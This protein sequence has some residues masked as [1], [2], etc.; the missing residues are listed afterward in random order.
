MGDTDEPQSRQER[1]RVRFEVE[2]A[3]KNQQPQKQ[4]EKMVPRPVSNNQAY[5]AFL[6]KLGPGSLETSLEQLIRY[7]S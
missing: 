4:P 7:A 1:R 5:Q 3:K 2:K 6:A